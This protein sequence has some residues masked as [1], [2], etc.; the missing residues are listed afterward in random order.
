[1]NFLI[2]LLNQRIDFYANAGVALLTSAI[3]LFNLLFTATPHLLTGMLTTACFFLSVWVA[4][5][6][7]EIPKEKQNEHT[8]TKV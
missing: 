4:C 5:T 8:Y 7:W 2:N 6:I 1:M 3:T